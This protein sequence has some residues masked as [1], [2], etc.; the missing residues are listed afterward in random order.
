[1]AKPAAPATAP[2]ADPETLA[3]PPIGT[4]GIAPRWRP[5][6]GLATV[7]LI[8][9]A[10]LLLLFNAWGRPPII[11]F[12]AE[13]AI[14]TFDV[15]DGAEATW[16]LPAKTGRFT[17]IV[18]DEPQDTPIDAGIG[19]LVLP[20]GTRM[21]VI[22]LPG[23][24]LDIRIDAIDAK[25][26]PFLIDAAGRKSLPVHT[27]IRVAGTANADC[28]SPLPQTAFRAVGAIEV[29]ANLSEDA[30]DEAD[31]LADIAEAD[32][33]SRFV[34]PALQSGTVSVLGRTLLTDL[35]YPAEELALRR[36]DALRLPPPGGDDDDN[37]GTFLVETRG[38]GPLYVRGVQL[39]RDA[40]LQRLGNTPNPIRPS[41]WQAITGDAIVSAIVATFA[42]LLGA[43]R[44]AI[45]FAEFRGA[46]RTPRQPSRRKDPK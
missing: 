23:E 13:T 31:Q 35:P 43:L 12:E 5:L 16:N 19:P 7:V 46:Y 6:A 25:R 17:T 15:T 20:P 21:T 42:A 37:A 8:A 10:L 27:T 40:T 22:R 11:E 38:C 14:F 18:D 34:Q 41:L 24:P 9:A 36:G 2:E 45:D 33:A 30:F 3:A 4:G 44:I 1:M 39:T 26:P 28:R 32:F 29:G